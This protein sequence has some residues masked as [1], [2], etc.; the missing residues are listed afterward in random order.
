MITVLMELIRHLLTF[1]FGV[2]ISAVFLGIEAN[3]KNTL[4]LSVFSI[5]ALL[6]QGVLYITHNVTVITM[7]YPVIIHLP[8]LM[9]F[10]FL[11]KKKFVPSLLAI[12]TA[13]LCCQI[14]NWLSVI[15]ESLGSEIWVNDLVYTIILICTFIIVVKYVSESY[16]KLL[17]KPPTALLSFGII[18]VFYYIFDYASTVYTELLHSG[19]IVA[20]EFTPFLM[21]VCYMIFCTAY[22]K[23]YEEKT[24]A[25]NMNKLMELKQKHSDKEITLIRQSEKNIALLRHDMR[26]FFSN[27]LNYIEN[28]ETDRAKDYIRS[29][30]DSVD[31]TAIKKY[32]S[33]EAVNMI[34]SSYKEII[35][36]NDIDFKHEL[37]IPKNLLVDDVDLTSILSNGM[38]N[39]IN[40]V[41]SQGVSDRIIELSMSER[42]G[43]LLLSLANT[44]ENAPKMVDGMPV[45]SAKGHGLGT[46]SIY[47][48]ARKLNGNCH[49]LIRENRFIMQ[50]II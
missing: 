1:L 36:D 24:E 35:E 49:F 16:S 2:S 43:K 10:I 34:L 4:L 45:S 25:E 5:V 41:L 9:V 30:I 15:P 28:D 48:T 27:I 46:Q 38:E 20:I 31:S 44:Y 47:Y 33:N 50:V 23:Q 12:T 3:R 32:C 14:A 11:F 6:V 37:N 39:A 17:S 21:S 26:H 42:N 8:L 29:I 18:P 7:I 19:H 40:A 13:Y 22:F